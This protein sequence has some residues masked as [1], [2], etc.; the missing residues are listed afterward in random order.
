MKPIISYSC[1]TLEKRALKEMQYNN[2]TFVNY[3]PH[4]VGQRESKGL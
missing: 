2:Y 1:K 3:D 4:F